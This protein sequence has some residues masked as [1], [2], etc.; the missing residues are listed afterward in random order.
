MYSVALYRHRFGQ[1]LKQLGAAALELIWPTR[2]A[3]CEQLGTLLCEGC[4]AALPFIDQALACPRC[5]APAGHLVCTECSPI[6]KPQV[7]AFSQARCA[8]EFTELTRRIIVAYKDGGERRLAPLLAQFLAS[9][10]PPDW[11]RWADALTWI[12]A[13]ERALRRR[14]F[15][16]MAL[17]ACSLAEQTGLRALPLL[18]KQARAD[19]RRLGRMRRAYN[20]SEAFSVVLPHQDG[21]PKGGAT[22]KSELP[23]SEAQ[24]QPD[25]IPLPHLILIDDVFTTGATLDAATRTL[26]AATGGAIQEIRIATIG[27]VW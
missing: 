23:R 4:V 2:C 12:P 17:V 26:L 6:Y 16:H 25:T 19:Q 13:D 18:A 3:G 5:G 14:G 7:F 20:M 1:A 11:R 15:D 21:F 8:L 27:R 10:I 9:A 22:A 24:R